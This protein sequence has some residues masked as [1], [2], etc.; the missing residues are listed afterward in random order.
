[1][2]SGFIYFS[3][4]GLY[5]WPAFILTFGLCFYLYYKT[6]TELKNLEKIFEFD[7]RSK[8]IKRIKFVTEKDN[9]EKNLPLNSI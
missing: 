6:K 5:I 9:R 1:M 4:Y 3:G 7:V 8:Q 2:I